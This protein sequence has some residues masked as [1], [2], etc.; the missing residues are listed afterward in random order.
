MDR[1]A[2][3]GT[4]MMSQ[5]VVSPVCTPSRYNCLTGRYASRATNSSFLNNTKNNGGQT[6]I[7]W[8]SLITERDKILPNYLKEVGYIT[9]MVGKNHVIEVTGLNNFPD[10]NADP[11]LPKIKA[12][13]EENYG[14]V[15]QTILNRGFDFAGGI[16]HNNPYGI[17]VD[18]LAVHNLDWITEA[19][20]RFIDQNHDRPFFLYKFF[21]ILPVTSV[22]S[23]HRPGIDYGYRASRLIFIRTVVRGGTGYNRRAE[24]RSIR[25]RINTRIQIDPNRLA[26]KK[27]V[28]RWDKSMNWIFVGVPEPKRERNDQQSTPGKISPGAV[29]TFLPDLQN[30][31]KRDKSSGETEILYDACPVAKPDL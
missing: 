28:D 31:S 21:A 16:Y 4:L 14:K 8:N 23:Y 9:G 1:L 12:K 2:R 20:I 3:E 19:G 11:R 7:Q 26:I 25:Y 27:S 24:K 30:G 6:V 29:E 18:E 13:I 10:F 17:G 5:Y 22:V 15:E